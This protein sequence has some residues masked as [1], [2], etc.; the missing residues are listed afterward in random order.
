MTSPRD[1]R[2]PGVVARAL[3]ASLIWGLLAQLDPLGATSAAND[4]SE[5]LFNRIYGATWYRSQAQDLVTVVL[6]DDDYVEALDGQWPVPF[7]DQAL[8]LDQILQHGPR[9]VFVDLAYR[10]ARGEPWELAELV[11]TIDDGSKGDA[12]ASRVFVPH[13]MSRGDGSSR[14]G[15][16]ADRDLP[17]DSTA[18]RDVRANAA[19]GV[20]SD[21]AT[22]RA[23]V[24]YVGWSECRDR[25]PAY[26][27]SEPELPTPAF[28]LFQDYCEKAGDELPAC[29]DI[30][31][32][33]AFEEPMMVRWGLGVS[34]L[35]QQLLAPLLAEHGVTCVRASELDGV[36]RIR[37]VIQQ[38]SATISQ[39]LG[40]GRERG[41]A[42]PCL[43]TDTLPGVYMLGL[44]DDYD[45]LHHQ[46][47]HDRVV[48]IGTRIDAVNDYALSPV[49][50]RVPGVFVHAM[51]LD[52]YLTY[53]RRYFHDLGFFA[54][55]FAEIV[56]L[57]LILMIV[58]GLWSA[59]N[60]WLG[61][62][63]PVTRPGRWV[64]IVAIGGLF[65]ILLPLVISLSVAT[66]L[67]T[68]RVAPT[69]WIGVALLSFIA[70]PVRLGELAW[71][72]D[73]FNPARFVQ[74]LLDRWRKP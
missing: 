49:N 31:D 50:N 41:R 72:I 48:L 65:T 17:S 42:E 5:Q 38:V 20:L 40:G 52:N 9:S 58:G 68:L 32:P 33:G 45:E 64:L 74:D 56:T 55:L 25:Y 23:N 16:C 3:V 54:T 1:V 70:N 15:G 24:V 73:D 14:D 22:S 26:Y 67:W 11:K 37:I 8:L 2:G 35:H 18:I 29:V 6:I 60:E 34:E 59:F 71:Q 10:H 51:A 62:R 13:L 30:A 39:S 66:L 27:R 57:F 36:E 61:C 69:N 44:S 12:E 28:A 46:L 43:Y 19:E 53:G 47:F 21:V 63:R 7:V 4:Q